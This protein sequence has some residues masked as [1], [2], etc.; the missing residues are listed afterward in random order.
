MSMPCHIASISTTC[1][2]G[3]GSG[4]G[5]GSPTRLLSSSSLFKRG[6]N[7]TMGKSMS[8]DRSSDSCKDV[9]AHR[10][11]H[12]D[13]ELRRI[14]SSEGGDGLALADHH[15]HDHV[16]VDMHVAQEETRI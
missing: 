5:S 2:S 11:D 6:P 13:L 4:S 16:R 1:R 8:M 7:S 10:L 9:G 14:D 15:D 3:S 12:F